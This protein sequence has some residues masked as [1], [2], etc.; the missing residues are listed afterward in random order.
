[1]GSRIKINAL[2]NKGGIMAN[3]TITKI[4]SVN[5][6]ALT[7][8][9][10]PQTYDDLLVKV[11]CRDLTPGGGFGQ[12]QY[13]DFNGGGSGLFS[14]TWIE[15]NGSSVYGSRFVNENG[16][17]LGVVNSTGATSASLFG[18][19]DIYIPNYRSSTFKTYVCQYATEN[20]S[21]SAY[22]GQSG[23]IWRSTAA[24]TRIGMGTG[25]PLDSLC[26]AVLYGIK[27]S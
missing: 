9:N 7:F 22:M 3:N 26:Y 6:N 4:A 21:T 11:S 1:M 18:S 12:T 20:N 25:F 13:M 10:I 27:N 5:A 19:Y 23:G 17:R 8:D 2:W 16:F 15:S 14:S 24:I